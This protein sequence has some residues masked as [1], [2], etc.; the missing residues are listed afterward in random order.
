MCGGTDAVHNIIM[1]SRRGVVPG[2]GWGCVLCDLPADGAA[3]V[4]CDSCLDHD[5]PPREVVRGYAASGEREPIE[6]LAPE[7][8]EHDFARHPG[9][10]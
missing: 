10:L 3:Y 4:C 5:V 2:H 7:P 8:F 9:E 1:L 6:A